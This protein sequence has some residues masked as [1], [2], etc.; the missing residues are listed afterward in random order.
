MLAQLVPLILFGIATGFSPGPNNI[1]TSYTAFNFGVKKA[2][3]TMLGVIIGWTL[4]IILLQL[5]SAS[6]FKRFD[7][8]QVIIKIL[9]SIYLLYMAYKLSFGGETKEKKID[10]KPVTFVNTFFFQFVNPKSIIVGLT[11]ISLFIDT[12]NNYLRDSIILTMLWFLMA[13]GSQLTW[14][15]LGK[16]MR[17]FATSDKFIKNFNYSM[18]FLLIVCVILFYV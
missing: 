11:S 17:K 5:G 18:S 13:I 15:L 14:C 1:M 2:I 4:L 6:V 7:T 12:E 8:I 9:G 16:Y 3:P 10:P